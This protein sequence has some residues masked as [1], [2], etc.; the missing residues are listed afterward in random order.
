MTYK[1]IGADVDMVL[2]PD[3]L[4]EV[5]EAL[6]LLNSKSVLLVDFRRYRKEN[7]FA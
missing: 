4:D 6:E 1:I 5:I 3:E 7:G 2:T